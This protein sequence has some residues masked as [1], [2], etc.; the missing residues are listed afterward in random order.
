MSRDFVYDMEVMNAKSGSRDIV[1]DMSPETLKAMLNHRVNFLQEELDEL[2]TAIANDDPEE[3]VDAFI[4][5]SVVAISTLDD[6]HIDIYSA[7]N[8]VL[9][10]N[11]TKEPGVNP[12]RPN[13]LG[14]PDMIKPEDWVPPSHDGNW[15]LF[16]KMV[17]KED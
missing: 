8:E 12:T 5:M 1:A 7:W 17:A 4:D 6:F 2:K 10:A 9:S 3:I 13:P 16:Y 15:G 14:L 11:L